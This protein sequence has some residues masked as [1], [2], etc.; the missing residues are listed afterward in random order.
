MY[1]KATS[2]RTTLI[3]ANV[4]EQDANVKACFNLFFWGVGGMFFT[5]TRLERCNDIAIQASQKDI[6]V[7]KCMYDVNRV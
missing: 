3:I 1:L 5:M 4:T 7:N 2:V 6:C